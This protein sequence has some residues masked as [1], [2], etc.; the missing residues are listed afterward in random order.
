MKTFKKV[1]AVLVLMMTIVVLGSC[2]KEVK[3]TFDYGDANI[4]NEVVTIKKGEKTESKS[5]TRDGYIFVGWF[6]DGKEFDFSEPLNKNVTVVAKWE[7]A[8]S[9]YVLLFDFNYEGLTESQELKEGDKATKV[10]V[11]ERE[12]FVFGG[13][14]KDDFNFTT[15]WDFEKDLMPAE[16]ITIYAKWESVPIISGIGDVTFLIGDEEIDLLEGVSATDLLEASDLDVFVE[17]GDLDFSK[18]GVYE[19]VYSATN[20][21]GRETVEIITITVV[22]ENRL[23][24]KEGETSQKLL[25]QVKEEIKGFKMEL[26]YFIKEGSGLTEV[27]LKVTLDELL[28]SWI[29]DIN[30][31]D[32]KIYVATTGLEDIDVYLLTEIMSITKGFELELVSL[33]VDTVSELELVIK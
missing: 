5:P 31:A 19:V 28:G 2:G 10:D 27:D 30:I 14:F 1:L 32:G 8:E 26:S 20:F 17:E 24:I 22:Y 9:S 29:A 21:D 15:P 23:L 33:I 25:L 7:L 6:V 12:G 4:A 13:W 11:V 18:E 16:S 3:V